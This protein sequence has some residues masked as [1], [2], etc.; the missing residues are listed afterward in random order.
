VQKVV[1]DIS[2]SRA[3]AQALG[4]AGDKDIAIG[5]G[6]SAAQQYL[7]AGLLDEMQLH[8]APF[9][10]GGGIRL[11]DGLG[12]S[13]SNRSASSTHPTQPTCAIAS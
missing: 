3:L 11:F 9:L 5:G 13:P 12:A 7:E 8:Y 2:V 10:L 6:A 4:V 1:L